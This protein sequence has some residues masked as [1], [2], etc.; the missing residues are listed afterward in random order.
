MSNL[1][2]CA[3]LITEGKKIRCVICDS[4]CHCKDNLPFTEKDLTNLLKWWK[5]IRM[6]KVVTNKDKL[7]EFAALVDKLE[8]YKRTYYGESNWVRI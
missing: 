4:P 6:L 5:T 7:K 2:N 1:H 3:C 8:E